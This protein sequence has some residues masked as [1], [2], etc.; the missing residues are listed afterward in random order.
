[1][2]DCKSSEISVTFIVHRDAVDE[3]FEAPTEVGRKLQAIPI[4]VELRHKSRFSSI[5]VGLQRIFNWKVTRRRSLPLQM[6][7]H[8]RLLRFPCLEYLLAPSCERYLLLASI[9]RHYELNSYCLNA[10]SDW[11]S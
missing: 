5:V 10:G 4:R 2:R 3:I 11:A 6:R 8:S 7:C 1:M 9:R